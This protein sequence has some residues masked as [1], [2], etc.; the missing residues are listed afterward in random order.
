[1]SAFDFGSAEAWE[2]STELPLSVG[3]HICTIKD[4]EMG[5]SSGDFPQIE[6]TVYNNQGFLRDWVVITPNTTGKVAQLYDSAGVERP[7]KGEYDPSTGRLT[8]KCV[9]RLHGKQVGVVVRE[10]PSRNDPTRNFREVAGYVHPSRVAGSSVSGADVDLPIDT[11]GF[12]SSD[13]K[14]PF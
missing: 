8:D 7:D 14:I 13:E 1:M 12:P 5:T 10:R 6:L 4:P 3:S 2:Q 11:E 9:Y